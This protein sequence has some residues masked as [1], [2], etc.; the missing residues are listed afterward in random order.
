[1]R[2]DS[3]QVVILDRQPNRGVRRGLAL[4]V[5]ALLLIPLAEATAQTAPETGF[6]FQEHVQRLSEF[7][8]LYPS[9]MSDVDDDH[10]RSIRARGQILSRPGLSPNK[11]RRFLREALQSSI[12]LIK[13][14]GTWNNA[15]I[16][17]IGT[18]GVTSLKHPRDL[19]VLA[20]DDLAAL[21]VFQYWPEGSNRIPNILDLDV[22]VAD[23]A[24]IRV[25]LDPL[26]PIVVRLSLRGFV[27]GP[28]T[29][30]FIIET[31]DGRVL[32]ET[33]IPFQG[34]QPGRLKISFLDESTGEE[35]GSLVGLVTARG[36]DRPANTLQFILDHGDM[37]LDRLHLGLNWPVKDKRV[38]ASTGAF[39]LPVFPGA[40]RVSASK[41]P[42]YRVVNETLWV[43]AGETVERVIT[44]PRFIDP[45]AK[46]WFSGD[47]HWHSPRNPDLDDTVMAMLDVV[48]IDVA[49]IV[50]MGDVDRVYYEQSEWG[51]ASRRR[52]G[53]RIMPA[54]QEDPR[55]NFCGHTLMYNLDEPIRSSSDYYHYVIAFEAAHEQ[56]G[57]VGF[58][59]N[60]SSFNAE[61]GL[62]LTAP[63]GLVDFVELN[64]PD[65]SNVDVLYST[66]SLG[67]PLAVTAGSDY[68]YGRLPGTN[69]FYTHVDGDLTYEKYIQSIRDGHTVATSEGMFLDV[70]L[71]GMLPGSLIRTSAG[72]SLQLSVEAQLNPDFG[73]MGIV[74]I[75]RNG[76][77]VLTLSP[78]DP[79]NPHIAGELELPA[80]SGGWIAVR[81]FGRPR[82]ANV[83]PG[84]YVPSA[85][86]S[87]FRIEVDGK[88]YWHQED[89]EPARLA[90]LESLAQLE[91]TEGGIPA[92]TEQQRE[93][94][95]LSIAR[96]RKVYA[97]RRP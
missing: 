89:H 41:G 80:H 92:L 74:E 64:R 68:P 33:A 72:D 96:A 86:T 48:D 34:V 24:P 15:F 79:R 75:V 2:N 30:S 21:F 27:V 16:A 81:A 25:Q 57:L 1:M 17:R 20:G 44:I 84:T 54:G 55:T 56:G 37:V 31:H 78:D 3:S 46:G 63:L 9:Q 65:P 97:D 87:A 22:S 82:L 13:H 43:K 49:N 29:V 40:C 71:N 19:R 47:D 38:F 85:H 11:Q 8:E 91:Q 70:R 4:L 83:A 62:A 51:T 26:V 66:W 39:E 77:V 5:L 60:G 52:Q 28:N 18:D 53:A 35:T 94:L 67:F 10:L 73:P 42:E 58:A 76:T 61:R 95:L 69:R 23:A 12:S 90:A 14:A 6:D 7:P 45:A 88:P 32:R 50:Q 59:H 93:R 36:R